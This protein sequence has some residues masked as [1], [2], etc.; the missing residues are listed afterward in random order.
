VWL[1]ARAGYLVGTGLIAEDLPEVL[2]RA[3]VELE[4]SG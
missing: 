4:H 3:L 1:H 2:P